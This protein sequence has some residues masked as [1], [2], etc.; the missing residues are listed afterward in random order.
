M[1]Q[2]DTII[3]NAIQMLGNPAWVG[4]GVIV[5]STIAIIAL[6][7]A[8]ESHPPAVP[9]LALKKI[10]FF[11]EHFFNSDFLGDLWYVTTSSVE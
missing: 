1:I 6:C 3:Q 9:N 2:I 10:L 4:I 8:S 5:S 11:L 7:K